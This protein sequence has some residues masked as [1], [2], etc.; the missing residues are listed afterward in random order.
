[1]AKDIASKF[2][3]V[4]GKINVFMTKIDGRLENLIITVNDEKY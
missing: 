4:D 2:D 1:M 3:K